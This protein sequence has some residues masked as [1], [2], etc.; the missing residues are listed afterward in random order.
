MDI[1][2]KFYVISTKTNNNGDTLIELNLEQLYNSGYQ[3]VYQVKTMTY[4]CIPSNIPLGHEYAICLD[5]LFP[6]NILLEIGKNIVLP[7]EFTHCSFNVKK[8]TN[9]IT[10]DIYNNTKNLSY[11]PFFNNMKKS[12]NGKSFNNKS[13]KINNNL[14]NTI[15]KKSTNNKKENKHLKHLNLYFNNKKVKHV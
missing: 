13:S 2:M 8:Y 5:K 10:D 15:I 7:E 1:I 6:F 12:S 9:K 14:L 4:K 3:I 11:T